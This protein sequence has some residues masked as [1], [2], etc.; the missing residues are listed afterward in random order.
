MKPE[1]KSNTQKCEQNG[2]G[3]W[4]PTFTSKITQFCRHI[5]ILYIE[6]CI[7]S[8]WYYTWL[9]IRKVHT[10][11][12]GNTNKST[13]NTQI[14]HR[15]CIEFSWQIWHWIFFPEILFTTQPRK[16][17]QSSDLLW[18]I[19]FQGL[20]HLNQTTRGRKDISSIPTVSIDNESTLILWSRLNLMDYHANIH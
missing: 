7:V 20:I 6:H 3:I 4:I 15:L 9:Y 8:L 2:A 17:I 14:W 11:W 1:G 10:I 19:G 16:L 5:D 18:D 13:R 12:C